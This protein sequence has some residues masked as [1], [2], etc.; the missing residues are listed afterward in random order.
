MCGIIGCYSNN[1][2]ADRNWL[3]K[4]RDRM[5][6]RGPDNA[7]YW[8]NEELNILFGH[9]RLSIIDLNEGSNQPMVI[10]IDGSLYTITFNGEIYNYE[11]LRDRLTSSGVVCKTSSDTEVLL[12]AYIY[13]GY[14]FV[15]ELEGMF[16]FTIFDSKEK[17]LFFARDIVGEKP[18]YYFNNEK[19]FY[20]SSEFLPLLS[21]PSLNKEISLSSIHNFLNLGY[22]D[23]SQSFNKNVKKLPAGNFGVFNLESQKLIIKSYYV[24][25]FPNNNNIGLNDSIEKFNYLITKSIKDQLRSDVP[26]GVLL[27]GGIDS[28][29]VTCVANSLN[30]NVVN[31]TVDFGNNEEE[32][33]NAKIISNHFGC[34]HK[35][36][37]FK[38]L[39]IAKFDSIA[40]KIDEP[41]T[42]SSFFPTYLISELISESGGKVVL[43]GDG[44][45]ELFG[46]Y[47]VY[48]NILKAQKLLNN[49]PKT[50]SEFI[51]DFFDRPYN[52]NNI[53]L[54]KWILN[55]GIL[56]DQ[57]IPNIR[58]VFTANEIRELFNTKFD[59]SISKSTYQDI[60][61]YNYSV[62]YNLSS[63]DL[64]Q[65][66]GSNILLKNDRASM[67]NS[68]EMRAPFLNK[69][70]I[71]YSFQEL[72]DNCKIKEGQNKILLIEYSKK[73][74]P[75][76]YLYNKKRGFNF[77]D[78]L[79]TN[80]LWFNYFYEVIL[81]SEL[82]NMKYVN[83][84]LHE[85]NVGNKFF[86]QRIYSLFII[87]KWIQNNNLK[88]I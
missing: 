62:L 88:I 17:K 16:A 46:G 24:I 54:K 28:S 48:N 57:K 6:Y 44:A 15:N 59:S 53:K 2:A 70:I 71:N 49:F 63:I 20:F 64:R 36:F 12:L 30:S 32:L 75:T 8:E 80:P 29:I 58:Q 60:F 37:Q 52:F 73:I 43:G 74:F 4:A 79:L 55:M 42:D 1:F 39:E 66:L 83:Y 69:E 78:N 11:A 40:N 31:Y 84:I 21:H 47:S 81:K 19:G 33:L 18:Y 34:E 38:E 72:N 7:G 67:L 68:I 5:K 87:S 61:N 45:D 82:F 85:A 13:W 22:L 23:E 77:T 65:Y 86:F 41:I 26:V 51:S 3:L 9:R 10:N 27:S 56:S 35:I 50:F 14:N 25:P 76:G